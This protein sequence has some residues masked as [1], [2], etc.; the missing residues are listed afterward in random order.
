MD[1]MNRIIW[2]FP[3]KFMVVFIDNILIY[4]HTLKEYEEHF[5]FVLQILYEKRLFAKLEKCEFWLR[6]VNFLE[7][8][9]FL[10]G[11]D[12]DPIKVRAWGNVES[13]KIITQIM[14][15]LGLA[16][17]YMSF[18]KGFFPDNLTLNHTNWEG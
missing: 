15:F 7:H 10:E 18:I 16:G 11:I 8:V 13:I 4:S 14:R 5:K 9:I 2:P 6:E 3:D 1:Y 17:Y 12:V